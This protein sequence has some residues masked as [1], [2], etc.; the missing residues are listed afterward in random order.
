MAE[1]NFE[2]SVGICAFANSSKGVQG[3]LK[4]RFSDFVV[5]EV[6]TEG[7]VVFLKSTSDSLD[8]VDPGPPTLDLSTPDTLNNLLQEIKDA[9]S[10]TGDPIDFSCEAE[11]V[12]FI[13][14]CLDKAEACP[15]D[16]VA[17][18]LTDKALR[19]SIHQIAKKY[20]SKFVETETKQV[21]GV[22]NI[23]FIARH[24]RKEK[25]NNEKQI[26][27][28]KTPWTNKGTVVY[29]LKLVFLPP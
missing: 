20:V 1:D 27:R 10:S 18:P 24:K 3:I 15:L 17:F 25:G 19:T 11:F 12:A 28:S 29:R 8:T 14:S 22:S 26:H 4:Q 9:R 6:T 16:F 21:E 5:R 7:E 23:R 13:E 2:E